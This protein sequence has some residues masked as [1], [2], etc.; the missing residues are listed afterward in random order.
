MGTQSGAGTAE[1]RITFI[2][3]IRGRGPKLSRLCGIAI[4]RLAAYTRGRHPFLA[5]Y[6]ASYTDIAPP[7]LPECK[8]ADIP[9]DVNCHQSVSAG[10]AICLQPA[11]SAAGQRSG[12]PERGKLRMN[13]RLATASARGW[14]EVPEVSDSEGG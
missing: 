14:Q 5:A 13:A 3:H 4:P 10:C 12:A 2:S 6:A 11:A 7:E 8:N 1:T 9:I